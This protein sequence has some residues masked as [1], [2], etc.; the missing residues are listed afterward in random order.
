MVLLFP[1]FCAWKL[2]NQ[3]HFDGLVTKNKNHP[4]LHP[5][6]SLTLALKLLP[7]FTCAFA[8]IYLSRPNIR[9]RF[10][11][12]FR[13]KLCGRASQPAVYMCRNRSEHSPQP[14]VETSMSSSDSE[15]CIR[16]ETSTQEGNLTS[17]SQASKGSEDATTDSYGS[18]ILGLVSFPLR[19]RPSRE[20]NEQGSVA[21]AWLACD[22]SLEL[23]NHS[24]VGSLYL[25]QG[26]RFGTQ[27]T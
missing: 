18:W 19:D 5:T 3:E 8:S 23:R 7:I 12:F 2:G 21:S 16:C 26:V 22:V 17:I 11:N 15:N 10:E 27:I 9:I 20:K 6:H 1:R 24:R 13:L 25:Y 4:F 14:S